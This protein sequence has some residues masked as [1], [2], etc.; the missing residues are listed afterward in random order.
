MSKPIYDFDGKHFD[1]NFSAE[2]I[3]KIIKE[4]NRA[5]LETIKKISSVITA[6]S[7]E[8]LKFLAD[9]KMQTTNNIKPN[10]C[11]CNS[12]YTKEDLVNLQDLD[13]FQIAD[14]DEDIFLFIYMDSERYPLILAPKL[15]GD[16]FK[17]EIITK[18]GEPG[19]SIIGKLEAK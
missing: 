4:Q 9:E 5:V 12:K 13:I 17:Y 11:L 8:E 16:P 2:N 6:D 18:I 7:I 10:R 19:L 15:D 3:E 14:I 1:T